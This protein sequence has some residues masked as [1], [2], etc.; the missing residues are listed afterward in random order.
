MCVCHAAGFRT[1]PRGSF[2]FG[3]TDSHHWINVISCLVLLVE[4]WAGSKHILLGWVILCLCVSVFEWEWE[5]ESESEREE[6][7]HNE[8]A[9]MWKHEWELSVWMFSLCICMSVEVC[10]EMPFSHLVFLYWFFGKTLGLTGWPFYINDNPPVGSLVWTLIIFDTKVV[11]PTPHAAI[12]W[13]RHD[14]IGL[15][16]ISKVMSVLWRGWNSSMLQGRCEHRRTLGTAG[17]CLDV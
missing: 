13:Y 9:C 3:Q 8:I 17:S 7:R 2:S 5:R 4:S 12:I 16:H 6:L 15:S 11:T 14:V 10:V 1:Q